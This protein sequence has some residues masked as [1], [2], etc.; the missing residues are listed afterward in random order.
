MP[1]KVEKRKKKG[2]DVGPAKRDYTIN[3]HKRLG[4]IQFKKRAKRAVSEIRKFVTQE[5]RTKVRGIF[6]LLI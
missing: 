5:M 3:M 1:K 6:N 2:Q 4:K